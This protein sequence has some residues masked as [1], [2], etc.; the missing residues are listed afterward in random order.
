VA[1]NREN[2]TMAEGC[3][4][5]MRQISDMK[6]QPDADMPFLVNLENSI[7]GYLKPPTA[8][9]QQAQQNPLAGAMGQVMGAP[10]GTMGGFGGGAGMPSPDEFRRVIQQ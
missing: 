9:D 8:A 2:N 10:G 4:K 6:M 3:T 5:L 1:A 7:L